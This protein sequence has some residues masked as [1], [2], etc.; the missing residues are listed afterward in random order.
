M[1]LPRWFFWLLLYV[2]GTFVWMVFFE[3][4]PGW[5]RFQAGAKVELERAWEGGR[6]WL[7]GKAGF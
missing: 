7:H 5:D 2:A 4:G 6:W 3:H 1:R